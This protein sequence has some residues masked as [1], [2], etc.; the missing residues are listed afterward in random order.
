[1]RFFT[2]DT[3]M[4]RFLSL[5]LRAIGAA[6]LLIIALVLV[7]GFVLT[8]MVRSSIDQRAFE[9]GYLPS[10]P[11]SGITRITAGGISP[12]WQG[13]EFSATS[14]AGMDLFEDRGNTIRR[15][16]FAVS[17]GAGLFD[18]QKTILRMDYGVNTNPLWLRPVLQEIVQT[19]SGVYLGKIHVRL[20]P[21]YP[22]SISYFKLT[23]GG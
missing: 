8:W 10:P 22:F 14:K 12:S 11:L 16:T 7:A 2:Y 19:G 17:E 5:L 18:T 23:T 20:L 9:N 13:K 15:Y 21:F 3:S 4:L 6:S 1:M